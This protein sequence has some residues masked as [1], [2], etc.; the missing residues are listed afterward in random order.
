MFKTL[1]GKLDSL[2]LLCLGK[3][4][5]TL[6]NLIAKD[7]LEVNKSNVEKIRESVVFGIAILKSKEMFAKSFCQLFITCIKKDGLDCPT[8]W[9]FTYLML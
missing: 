9:N 6:L 4:T 5:H 8:R 2:S 1:I 7:G 3:L